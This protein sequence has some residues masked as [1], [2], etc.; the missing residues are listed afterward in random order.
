MAERGLRRFQH[1]MNYHATSGATSPR[2]DIRHLKID[3]DPKFAEIIDAADLVASLA[4]S[5]AEAAFRA[6]TTQIRIHRAEF[7]QRASELMAAIKRV[8]PIDGGVA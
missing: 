3:D 4:K 6:D 5:I 8:A 7:R 2:A 1:G